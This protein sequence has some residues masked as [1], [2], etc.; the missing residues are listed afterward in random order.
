ME[1][2][3][4]V[5]PKPAPDPKGVVG[6]AADEKVS[7][8]KKSVGL[9]P[10]PPPIVTVP[11]AGPVQISPFGQHPFTSQYSLSMVSC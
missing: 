10:P 4:A 7:L 2:P 6:N 8:V 1:K 3:A 9:A 11:A 5:V